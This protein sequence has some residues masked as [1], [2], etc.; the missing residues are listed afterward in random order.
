MST[1]VSLNREQIQKQIQA[2]NDIQDIKQQLESINQR[3]ENQI[4][5]MN[6]F[7]KIIQESPE[8]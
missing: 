5:V 2:L 8:D 1:P 4:E 6:Y 3:V 7:L